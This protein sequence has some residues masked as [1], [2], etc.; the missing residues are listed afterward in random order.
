MTRSSALVGIA[1]L[2]IALT[3]RAVSAQE[4]PA[5]NSGYVST[6][7]PFALRGQYDKERLYSIASIKL[8][9]R[10]VPLNVVVILQGACHARHEVL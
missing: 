3:T 7:K 1:V 6:P 8:H 10:S 9:T 5:A 4:D 2:V